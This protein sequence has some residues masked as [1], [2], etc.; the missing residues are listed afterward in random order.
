L[1]AVTLIRRFVSSPA[2]RLAAFTGISSLVVTFAVGYFIQNSIYSKNENVTGAHLFWLKYVAGP[3]AVSTLLGVLCSR[4]RH[5]R[6]IPALQR[7]ITVAV[8]PFVPFCTFLAAYLVITVFYNGH[9]TPAVV[10]SIFALAFGT[11]VIM[12]RWSV[13]LCCGLRKPYRAPTTRRSRGDSPSHLSPQGS[14]WTASVSWT[15]SPDFTGYE[16]MFTSFPFTRT[17]PCPTI[18]RDIGRVRANPRRYTTLSRR[19]GIFK[20]ERRDCS[21]AG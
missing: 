18:C 12:V 2:L 11:V 19:H 8:T 20:R 16:G 5:C 21:S 4:A 7:I 13:H 1:R 10:F 14:L 17:W 3:L 15:E 6:N 9:Y